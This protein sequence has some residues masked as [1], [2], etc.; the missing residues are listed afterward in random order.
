MEDLFQREQQ[1]LDDALEHSKELRNGS[2]F[3]YE[4]FDGLDVKRGIFQS[5]G[6]IEHYLETLAVFHEDGL[7]KINEI[8]KCLEAGDIRLYTTYVHALKSA[9]ANIGAMGLSETAKALETAGRQEDLSFIETRG[10]KFLTDLERLLG[11]IGDALSARNKSEEEAPLDTE[12]LK[13]ELA[14]LKEALENLDVGV[15]NR[16]VDVLEKSART[17]SAAAAVRNISK[18]ILIAEY[19]EA[20]S[21][22]NALL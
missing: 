11:S 14:K 5:G 16:T 8:R 4:A 13:S 10:E 19:D 17:G 2:S 1:A 12:I 22:I 9:S 6:T 18:S 21:M 7:A 3:N 20:I 15:I